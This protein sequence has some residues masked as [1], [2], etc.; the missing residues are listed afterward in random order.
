MPTDQSYALIFDMDGVIIDNTDYQAEA[1]QLLFR[2]HGLTTNAQHLLERLNGMPATAILKT[3]FQNPVPE[4]ELK[5]YADQ[6]EFLYRVLYWEKRKEVKGL[7]D[8]LRAARQAGFKIAL[9]TGSAPDTIGYIID[10]LH[11]RPF[12]DVITGAADVEKGKPHADTF[13][14]A[15]QQLGVPPE[16]CVVFEDAVLGEQ[17]AYRAGMRCICLDT[18]VEA[19]KF[20]SPIRVIKDFTEVVPQDI[21]T[22]L[23]Q[24]PTVPKPDKQRAQRQYMKLS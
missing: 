23:E 2:E 1:F 18:S 3:V 12:F 24:H 19:S 4:K 17:A 10:H 13:T 21:I 5:R 22:L 11:L 20:Q 15:A 16:R 14:V 6:R 9:G 7:T 8:F